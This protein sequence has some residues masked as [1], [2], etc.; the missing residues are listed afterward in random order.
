MKNYIFGFIISIALTLTAFGLVINRLLSGQVLVLVICGLAVIQVC[1]QLI[2]FLHLDQEKGSPWNLSA[3]LATVGL[4][5]VLV[6]GSLWI[7]NNLNYHMSPSDMNN[8]IIHDEG[9]QK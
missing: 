1:V 7:M 5:L 6:V 8:Y 2:F 3:F 9:I 4:I